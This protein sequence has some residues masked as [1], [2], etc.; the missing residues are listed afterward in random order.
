[1]N[2]Q[3]PDFEYHP[4]RSLTIC[5]YVKSGKIPPPKDE[6][7]LEA[8]R[9]DAV[10]M[11][12]AINAAE[13]QNATHVHLD[14][15]REDAFREIPKANASVSDLIGKLAE[16][17][18]E[19]ASTHVKASYRLRSEELPPA[20]MVT[21]LGKI[22]TGTPERGVRLSGGFLEVEGGGVNSLEWR[23]RTKDDTEFLTCIVESDVKGK[24]DTEYLVNSYM[25]VEAAWRAVLLEEKNT[26]S[27]D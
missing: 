5:N 1:M 19:E 20:S 18:G 17:A 11:R 24:I 12:L 21:V 4:L 25:P 27:N 14:M 3:F 13:K 6:I 26:K 15:C 7:C 10:W 22:R 16:Y 23:F 2:F 8:R 9:E